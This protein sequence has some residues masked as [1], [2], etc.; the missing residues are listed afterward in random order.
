MVTK[1]EVEVA[2]RL[3]EEGWGGGH[4][5]APKQ[6]MT[7]DIVMRDI[8]GHAEPLRGWEEVRKFWEAAAPTL[9][10]KVEDV[11]ASD[12][13]VALTWIA[14]VQIADESMGAENKGKWIAGEGMSRLE[15]RD[16]KVSLEVDYWH[17]PQGVVE[18]WEPHWARRQEMSRKDKGA[19]T[20]M[21]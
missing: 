19:I 17:G 9:K 15:F 7:D 10:T 14:Y 13:G 8:V 2:R 12:K 3:F 6:F 11:Y 16:G 1:A 20:A 18:D 5:D 21:G 4:P